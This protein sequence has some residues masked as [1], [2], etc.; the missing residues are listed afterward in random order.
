MQFFYLLPA[1]V[2]NC[3]CC[4]SLAYLD[5]CCSQKTVGMFF[6]WLWNIKF[7]PDCFVELQ[8]AVSRF[9]YMYVN[10]QNRLVIILSV[11]LFEFILGFCARVGSIKRGG[12]GKIV[13]ILLLRAEGK[14]RN[15]VPSISRLIKWWSEKHQ[16]TA[17]SLKI[18]F[19]SVIRP[20][21]FT[22]IKL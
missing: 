12:V 11:Q 8:V 9:P 10:Y 5:P 20:R 4:L 16:S 15:F 6:Q 22:V 17:I 21:I 18:I 14:N 7:W 13:S 3:I 1:D 19:I 2:A